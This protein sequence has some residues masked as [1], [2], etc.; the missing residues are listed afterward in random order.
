MLGKG[1]TLTLNSS[2]HFP[3]V[4]YY[5]MHTFTVPSFTLGSLKPGP[6]AIFLPGVS[7]GRSSGCWLGGKC[8]HPLTHHDSPDKPFPPVTVPFK[9]PQL[10]EPPLLP[11]NA[12][13][14]VFISLLWRQPACPQLTYAHTG[15]VPCPLL[16]SFALWELNPEGP[17]L[18]L[19]GWRVAVLPLSWTLQEVFCQLPCCRPLS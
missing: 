7:P 12:L 10:R 4:G 1:S 6:G 19:H 2:E 11:F 3:I 13:S 17:S 8:P 18:L 5:R 14:L 9:L 16:P 15:C